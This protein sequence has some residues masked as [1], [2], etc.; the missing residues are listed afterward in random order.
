MRFCSFFQEYWFGNIVRKNSAIAEATQVTLIDFKCNNGLLCKQDLTVLWLHRNLNSNFSV[1]VNYVVQYYTYVAIK[2]IGKYKRA[3]ILKMIFLTQRQS[4]HL[5][6]NKHIIPGLKT[7]WIMWLHKIVDK[8]DLNHWQCKH[9]K[10]NSAACR[11][12]GIHFTQIAMA[13][14]G[15]IGVLFSFS[16]LPGRYGWNIKYVIFQYIMDWYPGHLQ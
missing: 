2:Y 8:Y 10:L 7:T 5:N 11:D 15:I 16:P 3:P 13:S 14:P 4:Y 9:E 6:S 12:Y 1:S